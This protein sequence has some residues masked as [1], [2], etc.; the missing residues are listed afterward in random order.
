[1]SGQVCL[2]HRYRSSGPAKK[3][4]GSSSLL[5]GGQQGIVEGYRADMETFPVKVIRGEAWRHRE[6]AVQ[7]GEEG[8]WT[9]VERR[10]WTDG[11]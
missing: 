5:S 6:R 9:S 8:G 10:R 4:K 1:M 11:G 7:K 2:L 3:E